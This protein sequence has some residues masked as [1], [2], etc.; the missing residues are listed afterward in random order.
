M[1]IHPWRTCM[2]LETT[3]K[4]ALLLLVLLAHVLLMMT[5]LHDVV[6]LGHS[7]RHASMEAQS[8]K[9]AT[10]ACMGPAATDGHMGVDCAIQGNAPPRSGIGLLL[11]SAPLGRFE[12]ALEAGLPTA[13]LER[14]TWPP[15]LADPHVL[16]QV[17]RL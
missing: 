12:P 2:T 3:Q 9:A 13:L 15:P 14:S 7:D 1:R 11:A 8:V 4:A 5:P 6:L 16:F 10:A 17:F